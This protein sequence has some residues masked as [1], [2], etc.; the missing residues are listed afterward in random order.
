MRVLA[1]TQNQNV[2]AT[3][4][5]TLERC[6]ELDGAIKHLELHDHDNQAVLR[7][8]IRADRSPTTP[9]QPEPATALG[10]RRIITRNSG[11]VFPI[12]ELRKA[13]AEGI[14][15]SPTNSPIPQENLQPANGTR[16]SQPIEWEETVH[17]DTG[18]LSL[19]TKPIYFVG[20]RKKFRGRYRPHGVLRPP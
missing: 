2:M 5:E 6:P 17:A 8:S 1:V 4:A 19:A 13:V 7:E 3:I 11:G 18:P 15:S 9:A 14:I 16:Q 20:R 12:Q 10:E